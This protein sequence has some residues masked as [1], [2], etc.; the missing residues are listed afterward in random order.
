MINIVLYLAQGIDIYVK[1][2]DQAAL[3]V[4]S[5]LQLSHAILKLFI[6]DNSPV[7]C[8]SARE[9]SI[10]ACRAIVI[11]QDRTNPIVYPSE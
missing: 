7:D 10:V 1:V 11:A 4:Q 8:K 2:V 6:F 5:A 3:L 9:I